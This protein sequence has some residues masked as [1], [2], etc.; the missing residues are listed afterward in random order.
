M[1]SKATWLATAAALG[2][3]TMIATPSPAADGPD[4]LMHITTHA[5]MHMPGMP[6]MPPRA[7][8]HTFCMPAGKF[9][10]A[11][12]QQ[13]TSKG[14]HGQCSVEHFSKQGNTIT[15]DMACKTAESTAPV[16]IHSVVQLDSGGG[17]TGTSQ[18]TMNAGGHAMTMD[19]KFTANRVGGCTYTPP[20]SS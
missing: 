14:S 7:I 19:S 17:Y 1:R 11:A 8:E 20:A 15:Y 16:T 3:A 10:P 13:A 2:V 4:N 5:T 18:M 12:M 6:A 9:D